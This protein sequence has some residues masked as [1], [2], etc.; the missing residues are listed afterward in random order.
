MTTTLIYG[1]ISIGCA[2]I[3]GAALPSPWAI[4]AG[5]CAGWFAHCVVERLLDHALANI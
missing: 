2:I 1:A 5:A 4:Y 3:A